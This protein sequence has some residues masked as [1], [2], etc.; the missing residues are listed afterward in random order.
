MKQHNCA[1]TQHA[2]MVSSKQQ[3]MD[4]FSVR[5][6]PNTRES[7]SREARSVVRASVHERDRQKETR[8][9]KQNW[10]NTVQKGTYASQKKT[11]LRQ[12][13]S[14]CL[15]TSSTCSFATGV[16]VLA[17]VNGESAEGRGLTVCLPATLTCA[18]V[19][20]KH[21]HRS[22]HQGVQHTLRLVLYRASLDTQQQTNTTPP[23]LCT[24]PKQHN[25]T[26]THTTT[27]QHNEHRNTGT[28]EHNKTGTWEHNNTSTQ[29]QSTQQQPVH[30]TPYTKTRQQQQQQRLEQQQQYVC[31][32]T[33]LSL[34]CFVTPNPKREANGCS[35]R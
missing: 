31:A 35:G 13:V 25:N 5:L 30:N 1:T 10:S 11:Y 12:R 16:P 8:A 18:T 4:N 17:H 15:L 26:T 2:E 24:T 20:H 6:E 9:E 14:P 28:Q 29:Q 22:Q 19:N 34:W 27:Q 23:T 32:R 3:T 33:C 7:T 21:L